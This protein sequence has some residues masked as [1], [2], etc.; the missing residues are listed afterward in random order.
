MSYLA[1][2]VHL[3]W[4]SNKHDPILQRPQRYELF[5]QI[6]EI[7]KSKN[8]FI[9]E[10]NGHVDHVHVLISLKADQ[11]L[12]YIAR[13]L[14]GGSSHWANN[15]SPTLFNKKLA[16]ASRYYAASVSESGVQNVRKYI[17]NQEAHHSKISFRQECEKFIARFGFTEILE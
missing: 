5:K 16:W 17:Q 7:A 1:V 15:I 11:K 8:I 9:M 3:V 10:I 6:R 12:S 2:Y 4:G 13:D 14:K